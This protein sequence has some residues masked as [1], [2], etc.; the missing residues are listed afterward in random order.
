MASGKAISGNP[1]RNNGATVSRGGAITTGSPV[2][3]APDS[4]VQGYQ[5]GNGSVVIAKASQGTGKAVSANAF[6]RNMVSGQYIM[7]RYGYL[8]GSATNFMNSGAGDFGRRAIHSLTTRETYH[9]TS[10]NYVTGA[11]TK[12][13]N[14]TDDF[15]ADHAA[16]PTRAVPGEFQYTDHGM[17]KS[18]SLA[19]PTLADYEKKND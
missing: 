5:K 11:A 7:M 16:A 2:T 18:G 17:A 6:S 10:W 12:G 4:T 8:A 9:I 1:Y 3:N 13:V 19:V 15:G 14:T